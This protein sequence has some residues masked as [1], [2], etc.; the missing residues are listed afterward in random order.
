MGEGDV[1]DGSDVGASPAMID[2][3]PSTKAYHAKRPHR[4]S[5]N[6]CRNCKKRKVK[7]DE[8][9]PSCRTCTLRKETCVYLSFTSATAA[10]PAQ[11]TP[12]SATR[13]PPVSCSIPD[14]S[15]PPVPVPVQPLPSPETSP[16]YDSPSSDGADS[17]A[18][19]LLGQQQPASPSRLQL[20]Q[21]PVYIPLSGDLDEVKLLWAY[22]CTTYLSFATQIEGV[23]KMERALRYKVIEYAIVNPFLMDCVL[24][25]TSMHM[26]RLG[27]KDLTP[28]R[29]KSIVYRARAFEGY[30]KAVETADPSTFPALVCCS[31]LL[32]A[33]SSQMFLAEDTAARRL[34][35]LNWIV[36]WRGIG[37]V[38]NLTTPKILGES[39]LMDIF[40]RP[41][42]NLNLSALHIPTNLLFMVTSI[43]PSDPDFPEIE[44]YYDTLK[45]LGSLYKEL[46]ENGFTPIL[47]LR[48]ITFYTFVPSRCV[49]LAR[50]KRPRALVILAYHLALLKLIKTIWWTAGICDPQIRDICEFLGPEWSPLLSV[51]RAA[52]KLTETEDIAK[53]LLGNHAWEPPA[54]SFEDMIAKTEEQRAMW[55]GLWVNNEG[56][57][58][59]FF[60]DRIESA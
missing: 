40:I 60:P 44:I 6:G 32:C 25:L 14:L 16:I 1:T 41:P 42:I 21:E 57:A 39:G 27:A 28:P 48:I 15:V 34:Y 54:M 4:K 19:T 17:L 9:R 3:V 31:L 26:E 11:S 29:S 45:F 18:L 51:P 53:L 8:G 5:R 12:S 38:L 58:Q 23:E 35:V 33:I 13:L 30:R 49:D 52:T 37:L 7:C 10:S 22:S 55:S 2:E 43:K 50:A 20:L 59:E 24:A 46:K 36:V 47:D 56:R